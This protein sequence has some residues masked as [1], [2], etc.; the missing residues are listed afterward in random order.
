MAHRHRPVLLAVLPEIGM[1]YWRDNCADDGAPGQSLGIQ[2]SAGGQSGGARFRAGRLVVRRSLQPGYPTTWFPCRN[3][4]VQRLAV[5][6]GGENGTV[7]GVV[8]ADFGYRHGEPHYSPPRVT[9]Q[10]YPRRYYSSRD[11]LRKFTNQFRSGAI[12][13]HWPSRAR[14]SRRPK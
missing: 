9:V 12:P 3:D 4:N 5:A 13:E 11:F 14:L 8:R 1:V 10:L 6:A 7:V 2:V